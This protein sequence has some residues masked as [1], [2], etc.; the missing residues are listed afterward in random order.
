MIAGFT[1][2]DRDVVV[3]QL[4]YDLRPLVHV[5]D[6]HPD[7]TVNLGAGPDT[8]EHPLRRPSRAPE[9]VLVRFSSE[10]TYPVCGHG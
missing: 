1:S 5:S 4:M 9:P 3:A 10:G 8:A 2:L 7:R 6:R